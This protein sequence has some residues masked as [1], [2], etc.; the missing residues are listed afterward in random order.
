M[1]FGS[2]HCVNARKVVRDIVPKRLYWICCHFCLPSSNQPTKMAV[3][4]SMSILYS[5]WLKLCCF[6]SNAQPLFTRP[7]FIAL[8]FIGNQNIFEMNVAKRTSQTN[9]TRSWVKRCTHQM[10]RILVVNLRKR[11]TMRPCNADACLIACLS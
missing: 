7:K 5:D 11:T 2:L 6:C 9:D 4:N 10:M 8:E 3:L 1:L